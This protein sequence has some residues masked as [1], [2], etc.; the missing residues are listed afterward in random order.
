MFVFQDC[1]FLTDVY[2]FAESVPT[3]DANAFG[4]STPISNITLH[5]PAASVDTY[6]AAEPWNGLKKIVA[7]STIDVS[8]SH[9]ET[10]GID[11]I[12]ASEDYNEVYDLQGRKLSKVQRGVNI[13]R[14]DGERTQGK[15]VLVNR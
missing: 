1:S 8:N 7:L 3:T 15:K 6:Q 5:V 11:N 4:G 2:C 12:N 10:T 13:I 9:C 14:S